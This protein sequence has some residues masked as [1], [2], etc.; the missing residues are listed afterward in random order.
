MRYHLDRQDLATAL[1]FTRVNFGMEPD[2]IV[3]VG[4][5]RLDRDIHPFESPD[6]RRWSN[7]YLQ[8]EH[9]QG[10]RKK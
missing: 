1:R 6:G 5:L 2:S 9:T 3:D 4:T 10:R 7:R 8:D